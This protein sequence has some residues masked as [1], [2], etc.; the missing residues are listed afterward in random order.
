MSL[1]L[2]SCCF[3]MFQMVL[4]SKFHFPVVCGDTQMAL[5]GIS[6]QSPS[7]AEYL[8]RNLRQIQ[9]PLLLPAEWKLGRGAVFAEFL[10]LNIVSLLLWF[11][12]LSLPAGLQAGVVS[13]HSSRDQS[14][15]PPATVALQRL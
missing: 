7:P 2:G 3:V 15:R 9:T 1:F 4:S 14:I 6:E 11:M 8:P 12:S 13:I 5:L 10:T